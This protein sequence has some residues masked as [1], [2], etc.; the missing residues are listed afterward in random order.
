MSDQNRNP[1]DSGAADN[2]VQSQSSRLMESGLPL[3]AGLRAC[4]EETTW[5]RDRRALN[6]MANELA[7]GVPLEDVLAD[8][9]AYPIHL[10]E[11]M[12]AGIE[13]GQLVQVLAGY[14]EVNRVQRRLVRRLAISLAYPF[15][16]ILFMA[17]V[18]SFVPTFIAPQL[19]EMFNSFGVELPLT[20]TL[21]INFSDL[22]LYAWPVTILLALLFVF[23]PILHLIL[24]GRGGRQQFLYG[25]PVFG[26]ASRLVACSEFCIM[27]GLLI[28][29]RIPLERALDILAR[30]ATNH[31][32]RLDCRRLHKHLERGDRLDSAMF[33]TRIVPA[34]A[35]Q[36]L[37]YSGT[38]EA[39]AEQLKLT[40]H[41]YAA[42]S[43]IKL[44][45]GLV[46]MEPFFL[47]A[48]ASGFAFLM[49]AVF[50][51]V[52]KLLNDLS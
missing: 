34:E 11:V 35:L 26:T 4:A 32:V 31:A 12:I 8:N 47:I 24:P 29:A 42:Q 28:R 6:R 52:M 3:E 15:V 41:S 38:P 21:L 43:E 49:I 39:L 44:R 1:G 48:F 30:T 45:Q 36:L 37:A 7:S 2:S 13:T 18:A 19:K 10:R 46:L 27:L 14:L 23:M 9:R 51:P 50:Q 5:R 20:T 33:L 22:I 17:T 40:G 25:V 16:I